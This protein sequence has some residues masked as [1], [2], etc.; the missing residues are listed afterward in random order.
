MII[1][2][3]SISYDEL[4]GALSKEDRIALWSCDSCIKSCSLGGSEKMAFAVCIK[5]QAV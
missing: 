4:K 5:T 1:S 3:R 2:V